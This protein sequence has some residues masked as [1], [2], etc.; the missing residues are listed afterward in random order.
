MDERHEIQVTSDFL[1]PG[2]QAE[3]SCGWVG[4][5]RGSNAE[6]L[7]DGRAHEEANR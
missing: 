5:R 1:R 6:A 4:D 7:A 3:C 2:W